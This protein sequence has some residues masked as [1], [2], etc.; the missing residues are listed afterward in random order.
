[1][2][3]YQTAQSPQLLAATQEL[4]RADASAR[5][6]LLVP[7]TPASDLLSKEKGDPAGIAPG[8]I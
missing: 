6:L 5:F 7:A 3:A 4:S 8:D 1:L 2:V